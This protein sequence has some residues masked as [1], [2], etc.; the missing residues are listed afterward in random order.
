[1]LEVINYI[2]KFIR[3]LTDETRKEA[4]VVDDSMY[5]RENAKRVEMAATQFDHAKRE[6]KKGFRLLQLDWTDGN[7]FLPV[8]SV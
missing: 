3:P 6:Y 4:F 7:T 5:L 8:N 1:M 2:L